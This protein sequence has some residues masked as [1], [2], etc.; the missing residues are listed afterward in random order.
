[1]YIHL[2]PT[3]V[4]SM[5]QGKIKK[6]H[7]SI[8]TSKWLLT[9]WSCL[10]DHLE[11]SFQHQSGNLLM[12]T[13][14]KWKGSNVFSLKEMMSEV[15]VQRHSSINT[16]ESKKAGDIISLRVTEVDR[17]SRKKKLQ[18]G[19]LPLLLHIFGW[20]EADA[21]PSCSVKLCQVHGALPALV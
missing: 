6:R 1:M 18:R 7:I 11:G 5:L 8:V 17:R 10:Q 4:G 14:R 3:G 20:C 9:D 16:D 2:L 15:Q 13:T 21:K 19:N 12:S